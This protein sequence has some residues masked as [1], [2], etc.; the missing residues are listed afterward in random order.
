MICL[1][2]DAQYAKHPVNTY[3]N[4]LLLQLNDIVAP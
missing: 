3:V 4:A 2:E 1:L